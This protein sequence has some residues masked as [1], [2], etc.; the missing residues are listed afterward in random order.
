MTFRKYIF[1]VVGILSSSVFFVCTAQPITE[2]VVGDT[3]GANIEFLIG[4]SQIIENDKDRL[5]TLKEDSIALE[6]LFKQLGSRFYEIDKMR[7][8]IQQRSVSKEY[9]DLYK[10]SMGIPTR[11]FRLFA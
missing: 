9:V 11:Y 6:P 2:H 8:S 4:I 3:I 10:L 1:F 7:D 5:Q